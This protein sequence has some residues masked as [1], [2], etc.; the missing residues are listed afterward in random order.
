MEDFSHLEPLEKLFVARNRLGML[1]DV[2]VEVIKLNEQ[3]KAFVTSRLYKSV[4]GHEA[5]ELLLETMM[6]YEIAQIC[7]LWDDFDA[8]GFSLPTVASLL[9]GT[10]VRKLLSNADT[11]TIVNLRPDREEFLAA[12]FDPAVKEATTASE[13][14]Q[15]KRIKNYRNKYI[16]HPIYRTRQELKNKIRP[17][18][19]ELE[20]DDIQYAVEYA[21]RIVEVFKRALSLTPSDYGRARIE[22]SRIIEGFY[23]AL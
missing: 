6:H 3:K 19:I 13:T 12:A 10:E 15:I 9:R 8:S 17:G 14:H 4:Q 2:L 21:F 22:F 1:S 20:P 11:D 18:D 23:K 7:R 5:G 16:A